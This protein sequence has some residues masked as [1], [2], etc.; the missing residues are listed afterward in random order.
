M[1][2]LDRSLEKQRQAKVHINLSLNLAIL[3]YFTEQQINEL[4]ANKTKMSDTS[5]VIS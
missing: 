5:S 4:I 2:K 1:T 3:N